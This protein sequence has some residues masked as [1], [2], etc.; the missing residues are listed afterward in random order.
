MT[1]GAFY[2]NPSSIY[3]YQRVLM[4]NQRLIDSAAALERL[5]PWDHTWPGELA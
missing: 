4:M 2:G 1:I 3:L 5:L